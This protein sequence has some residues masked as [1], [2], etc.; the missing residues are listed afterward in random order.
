[1]L[2][3]CVIEAS[4]I[5]LP[6]ARKFHWSLGKDDLG[7]PCIA[8]IGLKWLADGPGGG[9]GLLG[10][11]SVLVGDLMGPWYTES[12]PFSLESL[13]CLLVGWE[14]LGVLSWLLVLWTLVGGLIW[15]L[16]VGSFFCGHS[17]LFV[18]RL[19]LGWQ[20]SFFLEVVD[21]V[22]VFWLFFVASSM[23]FLW[24]LHHHVLGF[25]EL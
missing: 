17:G 13:L 12:V 10:C 1:M 18:C 22:E 9:L 4:H 2:A 8:G 24:I 23:A 15:V 7:A 6:L 21:D 19:L 14:L 20:L 11:V 16:G 25:L 3:A 5:I